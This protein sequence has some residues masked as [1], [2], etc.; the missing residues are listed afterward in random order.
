MTPG[1]FAAKMPVAL[2]ATPLGLWV[3]HDLVVNGSNQV[4]SWPGRLGP[5]LTNG[6]GT[7]GTRSFLRSTPAWL[8][9]T[10][11]LC[12]VGATL[13]NSYKFV[14]V[15]TSMPLLPFTNYLTALRSATFEMIAGTSGASTLYTGQWWGHVVDGAVTETITSSAK[16]VMSS[17]INTVDTDT[18]IMVGGHASILAR[19]WPNPIALVLAATLVPSNTQLAA[20]LALINSF[21]G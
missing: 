1:L 14:A 20:V 9:N 13:A 11:A 17:Y 12:N 2:G 15:V 3:G 10:S 7:L 16:V 5:T 21:I 8:G 18:N 19:Q 6:T 4:T